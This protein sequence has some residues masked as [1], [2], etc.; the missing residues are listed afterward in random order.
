MNIMH[1]PK[2]KSDNVSIQSRRKFFSRSVVCLVTILFCFYVVSGL[3]NEDPDPTVL[4]GMAG[5]FVGFLIASTVGI[6]YLIKGILQ[7]QT[8]YKCG[9][10]KNKFFTGLIMDHPIED[11]PLSN[12]RKVTRT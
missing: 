1:C 4:I 12:I 5:S 9:H 3:K 11:D 6:Y 7:K 8:N 2:C 10:C